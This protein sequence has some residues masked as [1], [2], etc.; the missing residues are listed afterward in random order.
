MNQ[1]EIP[2]PISVAMT[3]AY[4]GFVPIPLSGR[5]KVPAIK[6]WEQTKMEDALEIVT[7]KVSS[8][9]ANNIGVLCGRPSNFVAIDVDS[10]NGLEKWFQLIYQNC[11]PETFTVL[12]GSSGYHYYFQYDERTSKLH[13]GLIRGMNIDFKTT[14]GQLV[15]PGSIH[16]TTG[17]LY[18]VCG[19]YDYLNNSQVPVPKIAPMP[20]WLYQLVLSNQ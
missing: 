13:N 17:L 4:F 2:D 20:D 5:S 15:A 6:K 11:L 10:K 14:G 19:G 1:G 16:P 7:K 3:M 18:A 12:T 8:G 9:Q